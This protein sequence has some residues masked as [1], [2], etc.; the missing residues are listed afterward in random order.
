MMNGF[1][2]MLAFFYALNSLNA[3]Q[4]EGNLQ[5]VPIGGSVVDTCSNHLKV[6]QEAFAILSGDQSC[7]SSRQVMRDS[8]IG[9][10]TMGDQDTMAAAR[11]TSESP[12][13][14]VSPAAAAEQ[15]DDV[16]NLLR[17]T[18]S[19]DVE[20]QVVAQVLRR[21]QDWSYVA[22]IRSG[23]EKGKRSSDAFFVAARRQDTC[24]NEVFTLSE[25]SPG[26]DA[27]L[28]VEQLRRTPGVRV[29]LLFTTEEDT[30]H[31]LR[32]VRSSGIVGRFV[33]IVSGRWLSNV[34]G[35][36]V[37][38][39]RGS[40]I[41]K[42][43]SREISG[44][45]EY[46]QSMNLANH[47]PIPDDWFEEFWQRSLRCRL[48]N[49]TTVMLT[50]FN[51]PCRANGRLSAGDIHVPMETLRT[52]IATQTLSLSLRNVHECPFTSA[53]AFVLCIQ[54]LPGRADAI[55]WALR[56]V[57]WESPSGLFGQN[58]GEKQFQ[59]SDSGWGNLGFDVMYVSDTGAPVMVSVSSGCDY[60]CL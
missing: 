45:L 58:F 22:V 16:P 38:V 40:I 29:V 42:P 47:A 7:V 44:F 30:E 31:V 53:E 9:M 5:S 24:I 48:E 1:P 36:L 19:P 13:A 39:A 51:Q 32:A 59:F 49:A 35:D 52:I 57:R 28:A 8:L 34:P 12:V 2:N 14:L 60:L 18:S 11:V 27:S 56:Q 23:D 25:A 21:F 20:G 4:V 55:R 3:G 41:I 46:V 26:M 54:E 43:F 15:L 6:S 10:V 37:D 17:V 50:E 33:F